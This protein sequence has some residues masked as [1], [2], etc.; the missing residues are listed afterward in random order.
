MLLMV[1]ATGDH[2]TAICRRLRRDK[3][4]SARGLARTT[5]D[6]ARAS[7]LRRL[8]VDTARGDLKDRATLEAAC[9]GVEPVITTATITRSRQPDDIIQRVDMDN[10][11]QLLV[12]ADAFAHEFTVSLRDC[13][14]SLY[15]QFMTYE[16][17]A[18][19]QA[20]SDEL[21]DKAAE[22]VD[23]R[24]MVDGY[25]DFVIS[26]VYPFL[27][28]RRNSIREEHTQTQ[29]LFERLPHCGVAVKRT[30]PPGFMGR[31]MLYRDHKK[32]IV[33]DGQIAFVG[34]INISDHNYAWHDFV[35]KIKGPLVRDLARDFCSTWDGDTVPFER[36]NGTGD[37]ILNQC[38]G[39]YSLFEEILHRIGQ[40]QHSLVIES[41]YL[42]GNH[43]ESHIWNAAERGVQVT[44]I[45]PYH[46][47]KL[48]YR[49]WVRTLRRRLDHPN[50]T[51]YGYQGNGGMTHAKLLIVDEEWASFGSCNMFELEGLT[52][53]ELN[54]FSNN[55]DLIAQLSALVTDDLARAIPLRPPKRAFGRFT[56]V[57]LYQF[58]NWWTERLLRSPKWTKIYC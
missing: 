58:V 13:H 14:E 31:H 32:T 53:K 34:G 8:G 35:V 15:A 33:M 25:T 52:L 50:I 10:S 17:D 54:V 45:T 39:R 41:P 29:A 44:L 27:L 6:P 42:L 22:G 40:A 51:I 12:G 38:A 46:N 5:S 16:G 48:M 20:F 49:L 9:Q 24:L 36:S 43:L 47:N 55:A 23:V 18:T 2:G 11:F 7:Y 56:F 28:H 1:G 30:A 3:V 21:V 57:I 26:D 4:L 19:G 37:Y